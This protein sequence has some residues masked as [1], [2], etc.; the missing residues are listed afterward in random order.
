MPRPLLAPEPLGE[1]VA[2]VEEMAAG[3]PAEGHDPVVCRTLAIGLHDF[4]AA[5]AE[6]ATSVDLG[7]P[8]IMRPPGAELWFEP[9]DVRFNFEATTS[10]AEWIDELATSARQRLDN[11]FGAPTVGHFDWRVENL[12]FHEHR[13]VGIYDWDSVAIAPEAVVVGNTAAQFS[14]DWASADPDPLPSL[15]EMQS[16]VREYEDARGEPF[17][18]VER[19]LLDAANLFLCAYGA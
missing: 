1:G 4:V 19:G 12:G 10:G 15:A 18:E 6:L 8:L 5:G 13:I 7:P 17:N 16:F 11:A 3:D 14:A 2:T 9:H